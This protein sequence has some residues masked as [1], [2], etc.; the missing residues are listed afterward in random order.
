MRPR[1]TPSRMADAPVRPLRKPER[2]TVSAAIGPPSTRNINP[3]A[4]MDATSGMM[5]TGIRLRNQRGTLSLAKLAATTP[6]SR[7]PTMPPRKP[8]PMNPATAPATKPGAM[9]GRSAM[10]KAMYPARAG[11]RKPIDRAPILKN[12]A[13]R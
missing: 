7:P 12:T 1:I 10:A 8:A 13:P 2:A 9:P 6:A 11:T 4:T 3:D 5:T